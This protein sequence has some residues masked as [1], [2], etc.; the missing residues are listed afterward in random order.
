[1]RE[2]ARFLKFLII[3]NNFQFLSLMSLKYFYRQMKYSPIK[4]LDLKLIEK[5]LEKKNIIF[6][7]K[8]FKYN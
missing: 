3:E 2:S 5:V 7:A 8:A 6:L 4:L 1:V